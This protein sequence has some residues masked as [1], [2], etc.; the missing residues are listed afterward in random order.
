MIVGR[1]HTRIPFVTSR[2][3]D[4]CGLL[5]MLALGVVAACQPEGAR[6]VRLTGAQP[7]PLMVA[8]VMDQADA[9]APDFGPVPA[10]RALQEA[11]SQEIGRPVAVEVCFPFQARAGFEDG[12]YDVA[13][14]APA[15][16]AAL[17]NPKTLRVLTVT[18]NTQGQSLPA[19]LQVA[20]P[21][22]DQTSADRVRAFLLTADRKHPEVVAPLAVSGYVAPTKEMLAACYRLIPAEGASLPAEGPLPSQ[23]AARGSE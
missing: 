13:F 8:L 15:Q 4:F 6:A 5:S 1:V 21:R 2:P 3:G 7:R 17:R 19:Q 23:P 14:V 12:W 20:A 11:M 9:A 18:P 16:F 22:L 10:Y